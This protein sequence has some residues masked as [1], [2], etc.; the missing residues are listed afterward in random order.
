[1]PTHPL[2]GFNTSAP[3]RPLVLPKTT[4]QTLSRDLRS[5]IA[6][7]MQNKDLLHRIYILIRI[8]AHD[9]KLVKLISQKPLDKQYYVLDSIV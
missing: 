8:I 2:R 3:Q 6:E 5:L 9:I 4:A 7:K 1:M